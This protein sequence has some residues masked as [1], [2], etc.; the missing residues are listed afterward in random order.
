[1]NDTFWMKKALALAKRANATN[2]VPVGAVLISPD[3]IL[4]GE[5]FNQVISKHDPTAHAE[6][7]AIRQAGQLIKNYR[8]NDAVLYTTLEPCPMCAAALVH[9]RIGRLVFACRDFKT[10]AAGSVINVI[11]GAASNHRISVDEGVL[12][13]ESQTLL[14]AFFFQKRQIY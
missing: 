12:M 4:W 7:L 11:G 3:N 8:F 13:Q 2:E 9:A 5:G 10:G 6:I 1:M 14:K